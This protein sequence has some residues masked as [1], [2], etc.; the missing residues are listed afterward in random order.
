MSGQMRAISA[1]NAS[2]KFLVMPPISSRLVGGQSLYVSYSQG[3]LMRRI[4]L[5]LFAAL[6]VTSVDAAS[7]EQNDGTIVNPI[8]YTDG[9]VSVYSG[10]NLE[11]GAIL[12]NSVIR[13]AYLSHANLNSAI[14]TFAD[15]THADLTG[16]NLTGATL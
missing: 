13:S 8:L 12:T 4:T 1:F 15:L 16:A 10:N 11:P 2:R 5:F 14:L 7:Y 6:A 9:N 3:K